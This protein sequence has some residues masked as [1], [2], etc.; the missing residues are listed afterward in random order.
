MKICFCARPAYDKLSSEIY[1]SIKNN[2]KKDIE[3]LFVTNDQYE[4]QYIKNKIPHSEVNDIS[5][6]IRQHREQ[7]NFEKFQYFEKK[8]KCAP[9]W[10][11]IYTDRFLINKSYDYC[12]KITTG[13]FMF[14]ENIFE[15]NN[16]DY[17]YDET[18][19]TLQS[20]IAYLVANGNR[21]KYISQ[22]TARGKDSTHHYFVNDPFQYNMN[23]ASNYEEK[24]YNNEIVLEANKYLEE[25]ESQNLKPV[26]MIYTGLKP[27]LRKGFL[28][29]PIN[30]F[31]N[32]INPKYNDEFSYMYY[33]RYKNTF[34]PLIFYVRYYLSKKY[35]SEPD[36][37]KKFVYFPLH[38]QPEAS[39][40]VCAQKYEKQLFFIDSWAKSLPADTVLFVKEHYALLG[41]RS[42]DFYKE[43]RK[44]P[45]VM[46][47]DP[48]IDSFD[49][50][51]KSVAVT[52]L[53]GTAG[54]EAMLL[55]K[56]VFLAGKILFD[57]A[58]GI[59]K[60]DE[61][62]DHYINLLKK[63]SQP[64]REDIIKYL[65]E[66]FSTLSEGNVYAASSDCYSIEN[67]NKVSISLL[68]QIN[69]M[70]KQNE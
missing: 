64:K 2:F 7:L 46:L 29:L 65:C 18:I 38:Y 30:W 6:F 23:F 17:Y 36:Y 41:N 47:I 35:Y 60:V 34:D 15:N 45:N 22:M 66:Y 19:A 26:N 14:F 25:F 8:Y 13:L 28:R 4:S 11:F 62:Y 1:L 27:K 59:I 12:I 5:S 31:K 16:I 63:W 70:E 67:I 9:L 21:V 10:K 39:T 57:N 37:S 58:P 42:R 48:W 53:T 43:L 68:N 52:T 51:K 20:Y 50:I 33:K 3:A 40:I 24:I 49:L 69:I 32:I 54:W 44:Y 61:I 56:P 55:R